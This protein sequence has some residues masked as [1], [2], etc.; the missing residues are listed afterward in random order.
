MVE[1]VIVAAGGACGAVSRYV[2]S[3]W[4]SP[5]YG[6]LLVNVIGC[7]FIGAIMHVGLTT[8]L[9]SR[10]ARVLLT[11]G[12]LGALTTFSTFTYESLAAA[13]EGNWKLA[14]MNVLLNL[15]LG[16]GA[17]WIGLVSSRAVFGGA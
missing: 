7:F 4:A 15:V 9:I 12:F 8:D 10:N 16:F 13:Q 5:P 17:T 3:G 11:T 2:I 6:T 1:I 14:G